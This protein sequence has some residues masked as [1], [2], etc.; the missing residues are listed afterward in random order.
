MADNQEQEQTLIAGLRAGDRECV[1]WFCDRYGKLLHQLAD[2][3]LPGPLRRRLGPEDVVQSVCRTFFRRA[4]AGEFKFADSANLW[5]LL[6]ALTLAKV[7]EQ[8]RFHR[9]K[10]RGIGREVFPTYDSSSKVAGAVEPVCAQPTPAEAAEFA[11]QFRQVLAYLDDEE[12]RL[13]DLKLQDC[14]NLDVADRLGCSER[15]VRRILKRV[16]A[17]LEHALPVSQS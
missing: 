17:R 16:Q 15:T 2:R 8:I 1:R 4:Q 10:K 9:R 6:C 3:H 12:R 7:Q 14:T 11:D 13:V 5:A